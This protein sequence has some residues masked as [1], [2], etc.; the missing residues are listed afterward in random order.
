M[1]TPDQSTVEVSTQMAEAD[2][3]G[4][5]IVLDSFSVH[6]DATANWVVRKIVEAREYAKRCAEWCTGEQARARRD[7]AFLLFRFGQ[8]LSDYARQRIAEQAGRRKSVCLPAGILG[9]RQDAPKLVIDNEVEVIEWA[10]RHR[11]DL[12]STV[13]HLS[14]SGLNQHMKDTG[15]VPGA[16][17]HIE[18]AQDK[19]YVK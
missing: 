17:A 9:F 13:E 2:A 3:D 1:T 12:V 7:E 6:D 11:P 18:P 4:Q 15:E 10:K 5:P 8:Q 16:G 19:F 14:K